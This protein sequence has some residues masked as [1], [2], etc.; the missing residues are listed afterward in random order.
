M[1]SEEPVAGSTPTGEIETAVAPV[2]ARRDTLIEI[3]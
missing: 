3:D 1:R 2:P